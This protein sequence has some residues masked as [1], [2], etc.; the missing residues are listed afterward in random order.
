MT[1]PVTQ[2][3][4]YGAL[5]SVSIVVHVPA[6]VGER[7]NTTWATPETESAEFEATAA[8][9]DS[10]APPEGEVSEPVGTAVID[11]D[12]LFGR[13]ERVFPAASVAR[14]RTW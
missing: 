14:A 12:R 4:E 10:D 5:E 2:S 9:P 3:T 6:P 7:W 11:L 1:P 8:V 13:V